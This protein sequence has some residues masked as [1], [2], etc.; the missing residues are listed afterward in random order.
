M[1]NQAIRAHA[2]KMHLYAMQYGRSGLVVS[3]S[4]CSVTTQV[5]ISPGA[6]VFT[7]TATAIDL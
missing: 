2:V 4:D 6:A 3:V 7:T 1:Y 5:Q